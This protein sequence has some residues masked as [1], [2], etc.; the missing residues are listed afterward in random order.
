[1]LGDHEVLLSLADTVFAGTGAIHGKG[2]LGN[3]LQEG[4]GPRDLVR[5]IH[6]HEDRGVEIAVTHMPDDRRDEI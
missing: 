6:H 4:P 5:I 1:M 2:A 3:S